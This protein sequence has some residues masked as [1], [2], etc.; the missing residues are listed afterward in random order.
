M[1]L[2]DY[3]A[4]KAMQGMLAYAYFQPLGMEDLYARDAYVMADAMLKTRG[5]P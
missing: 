5:T 4:A 3:F 1:S 2:R